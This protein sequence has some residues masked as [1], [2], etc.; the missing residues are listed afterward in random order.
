MLKKVSIRTISTLHT[1]FVV[2]KTNLFL[3]W[4][5]G[6]GALSPLIF[7]FVQKFWVCPSNLSYNSISRLKKVLNSEQFPHLRAIMYYIIVLLK[8]KSNTRDQ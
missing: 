2:K 5:L 3:R 6:K 8:K 1:H 4:M 7:L